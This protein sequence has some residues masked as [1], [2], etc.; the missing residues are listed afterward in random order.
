MKRMSDSRHID[1][2]TRKLIN[3]LVSECQHP[4]QLLELYYWSTEPE[5]MP[6]IR[7]FARMSNATRATL[8]DFIAGTD[9]SDLTA[10]IEK[11]GQI[12]LTQGRGRKAAA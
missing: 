2:S 1:P 3:A 10:E 4:V 11:N 5:L 8:E 7:A 9:P 6:I 12:R